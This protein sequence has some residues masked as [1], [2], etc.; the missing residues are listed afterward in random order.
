MFPLTPDQ[1]HWLEVATEDEG[2]EYSLSNISDATMMINGSL[3]VS[4]VKRFFGTAYGLN[5]VTC[6]YGAEITTYL[7]SATPHCLFPI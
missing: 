4:I 6:K 7:E 1:H 2:F 3:H 5:H